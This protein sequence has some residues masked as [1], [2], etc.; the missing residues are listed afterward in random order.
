MNDIILEARKIT[1]VYPGTVALD[2]ADFKVRKGQVNVLIGENG[3][4]KSTMMKIAAGVETKTSGDIFING[5]EADY[6]TP[7][8]AIRHGVGIIY[9][10]LNLFPNL[11]I[12]ENMFMTREIK[13]NCFSVDHKKQNEKAA[14]FLEKLKLAVSPET[15]VGNLRVGQQQLV[16]I[17]KVLSQNAEI[18]I[19]DEPT[20][21]LTGAEVTSLF[22]VIEDLKK[23]GVTV[24]YISHR[25]EEIMRIGDY[26]TILRDG[27]FIAEKKVN[28]IDIPWIIDKMTGGH[29]IENVYTRRKMGDDILVVKNLSLKKKTGGYIV[30]DVS[31]SL[32]AGEILGLYGLLGAGRTE[33]LEC[34][35]GAQKDYTGTISLNGK[36]LISENVN[37]RIKD[38]FALIPE[39]RKTLGIFGNMV[40]LENMVMSAL[41]RFWKRLF[42]NEKIE[43]AAAQD[44]V[45]DL[46]IKLAAILDSINSLS[47]GNQQKV[48][49]GRS[50]L[51]NPKVLLMDD[52]TRG[53]DVAS[54]Y[55]VY[56][57]CKKFAAEGI[58]II[59]VSSEMQEMLSIPDRMLVLSQGRIKGEFIHEQ[60]TEEKLVAASAISI[61]K[62][63]ENSEKQPE[64]V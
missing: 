53:I 28:E 37:G 64:A 46:N 16:E 45:G 19:M 1:K 7:A 25:L 23:H 36:M 58:G 62:M 21:A 48:I 47:G 61:E 34:L 18:I 30:Q 38:G 35:I 9:Q 40:I 43:Q 10:E 26:I 3:A 4:G 13:K 55:D 63:E 31:F 50:L 2:R 8:E 6:R 54:K 44:I 20:S 15:L 52:P 29:K 24:I 27:K 59:F 17:A 56:E 41:S 49:I 57:I 22:T 42:L 33:V 11:S 14:A 51:T 12:A 39:D 5:K 60:V 32:K